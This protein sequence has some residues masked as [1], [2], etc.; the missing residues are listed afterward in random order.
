MCGNDIY[1]HAHVCNTRKSENRE[2]SPIHTASQP[3][4]SIFFFLNVITFS[5]VRGNLFYYTHTHSF[6]QMGWCVGEF[7]VVN[8]YFIQLRKWYKCYIERVRWIQFIRRERESASGKLAQAWRRQRTSLKKI[9]EFNNSIDSI[10]NV[11][12]AF[13]RRGLRS[14]FVR[15]VFIKLLLRIFLLF[16][17]ISIC[18]LGH[19][20]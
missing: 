18:V 6:L 15:L 5:C 19:K 12:I 4:S 9:M 13:M 10:E 3:E 14:I 20:K 8:K 16:L 7:G 2:K 17:S 1:T 11:C